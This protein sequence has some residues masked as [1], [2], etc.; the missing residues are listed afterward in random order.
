MRRTLAGAAVAVLAS[1][2]LLAGCG[3]EE[4]GSNVEPAVDDPAVTEGD[5]EEATEEPTGDAT[6]EPTEEATGT[7]TTDG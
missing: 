5:L 1:A 4:G 7:A 6:G 3:A 2:T